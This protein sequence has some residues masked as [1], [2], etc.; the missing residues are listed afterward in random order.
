MEPPETAFPD[1]RDDVPRQCVVLWIALRPDLAQDLRLE[2][3]GP[4]AP[5][6]IVLDD[7]VPDLEV[8]LEVGEP[9]LRLADHLLG[10]A[11]L[12][13]V[14]LELVQLEVLFEKSALPART[15]WA[16]RRCAARMMEMVERT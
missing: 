12:A 9:F 16:I 15:R 14:A 4:S 10:V 2:S 8:D 7:L 5:S 11:L 6:R 13:Q 3:R 1:H